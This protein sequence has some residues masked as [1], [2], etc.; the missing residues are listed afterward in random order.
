MAVSAEKVL[1]LA[2]PVACPFAVEA[3]FPVAEF[4]SMALATKPVRF[5]EG[6][7]FPGNQAQVVTVVK[8]VTVDAPTLSLGMVEDDVVM[9]V[10]KFTSLWVRFHVGMTVGTREN[11]FGEGWW[12]DGVGRPFIG[13]SFILL[14]LFLNNQVASSVEKLFYLSGRD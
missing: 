9:H 11:V 1:L 14:N 3:D 2:V 5:G 12:R 10:N 6:Y 13:T 4:V 7:E 8:I